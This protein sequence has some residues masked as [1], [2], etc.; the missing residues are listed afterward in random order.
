MV[1]GDPAAFR[2]LHNITLE[3]PVYGPYSGALENHGQ[4][5]ELQRPNPPDSESDP[6]PVG[7]SAVDVVHYDAQS[8]WPTNRFMAGT[9][10]ERLAANAYGNDPG[11]WRASS[12]PGSPGK[13]TPGS[14]HLLPPRIDSIEVVSGVQAS[15]TIRFEIGA[16]QGCVIQYRDTLEQGQWQIA[17]VL[18]P[19]P[20][21]CPAV[22]ND[23]VPAGRPARFYRLSAP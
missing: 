1:G 4:A 19:S 23:P 9:S 22:F 10:L 16:G 6:V 17:R 11:N 8:P 7:Y 13:E 18:D 15:I 14:D 20:T 12:W 5:I 3:V 21:S 2:S